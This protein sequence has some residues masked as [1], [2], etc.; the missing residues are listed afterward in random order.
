MPATWETLPQKESFRPPRLSLQPD[1]QSPR[2][3]AE[4]VLA[5]F[6]YVTNLP[7]D[8]GVLQPPR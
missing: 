4:C 2:P 7:T 5:A 8:F 3:F 1:P 6:E